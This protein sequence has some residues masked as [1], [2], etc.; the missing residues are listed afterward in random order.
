MFDLL[1]EVADIMY[2]VCN[3]FL[4]FTN[5]IYG[6]YVL[7]ETSFLD[8]MLKNRRAIFYFIFGKSNNKEKLQA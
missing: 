4:Y 3:T 6:I 2:T 8:F 1:K 7:D 5:I